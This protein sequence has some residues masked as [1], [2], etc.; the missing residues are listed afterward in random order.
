MGWKTW[1]YWLR[2]GIIGLISGVILWPIG[3]KI[4][5]NP[6]CV[7]VGDV[8]EVPLYAM[9]IIPIFEVLFFIPLIIHEVLITNSFLTVYSDYYIKT[10]LTLYIE[11]ISLIT[12]A[13][14]IGA[15]IGWIYG[16]IKNRKNK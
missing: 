9:L 15:L 10:Y 1:P 16:K 5:N 6:G 8:C 2:G 12:Y 13:F 11:L 14:I 7:L 4:M 3:L